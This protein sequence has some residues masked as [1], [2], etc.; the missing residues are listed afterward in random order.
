MV[1]DSPDI[2]LDDQPH[3][4]LTAPSAFLDQVREF[5]QGRMLGAL[6]HRHPPRAKLPESSAAHRYAPALPPWLVGRSKPTKEESPEEVRV[7]LI[8]GEL[9]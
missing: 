4:T 6:V 1:R 5:G 2:H 8:I 7:R 3:I 9:L